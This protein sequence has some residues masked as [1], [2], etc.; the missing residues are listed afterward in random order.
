MPFFVLDA[1]YCCCLGMELGGWD[2]RKVNAWKKNP[3]WNLGFGWSSVS[4][5]R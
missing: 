4:L 2:G 1:G 3:F 5:M